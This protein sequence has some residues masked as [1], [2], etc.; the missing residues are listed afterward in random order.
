MKSIKAIILLLLALILLY[1]SYSLVYQM[2]RQEQVFSFKEALSL[3]ALTNLYFTGVIALIGFALP[4]SK[5]LPKKYYR[6]NNPKSLIGVYQTLGI[7]WFKY[8]LL[9]TFWRA[10][11]K[12]KQF[13]NGRKDGLKNFI[14][15][16]EQAEFGHIIS[17]LFIEIFALVMLVRSNFEFALYC[18][19]INVFFNFYP[20]VLQRYHR[21]RIQ[22]IL[23]S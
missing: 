16:S 23:E 13:F 2:L 22:R 11:K 3:A 17:F 7:K 20:V 8:F 15:Q 12:Q 19:V 1:M 14:F 5:L 10:K 6:I 4:S 21:I 18:S 9:I